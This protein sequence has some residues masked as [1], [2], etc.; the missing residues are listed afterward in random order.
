MGLLS[1]ILSRTLFRR[2]FNDIDR[3]VEDIR[4]GKPVP[5]SKP[6]PKSGKLE[7]KDSRLSYSS[8][9]YGEWEI[10][11]DNVVVFGEYTTDNGPMIDDWFMVFVLN[12][13]TWVEASNYCDGRENVREALAKRWNVESLYGELCYHTGF[14]SRA[15][16]PMELTGQPLF[17]FTPR[18]Q[19]WLEKIKAFGFG[20]IDKDLSEEV[21]RYLEERGTRE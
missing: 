2:S 3:M 5:K 19:S 12:D 4:A 15:I 10:S 13:Q 20:L 21:R 1:S 17:Q 18:H 9:D 16:W 11:V 8:P 14:A 7:L 6:D